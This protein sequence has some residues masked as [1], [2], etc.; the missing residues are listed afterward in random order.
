[1]ALHGTSQYNSGSTYVATNS[2]A[3]IRAAALRALDAGG[4]T[5]QLPAGVITITSPLPVG[6]GLVYR[7][8]AATG[9]NYTVFSDLGTILAGDGTFNCFEW[10]TDDVGSLPASSTVMFAD[11]PIGFGLHDFKMRGFRNGVKFG[12][13]RHVGL[14]GLV[15]DNVAAERCTEW[16]FWL[17]NCQGMKIGNI[18]SFSNLK[19]Q[20]RHRCSM[21][22]IWYF[23]N[24]V[25]QN[26][27]CAVEATGGNWTNT[28]LAN[29]RGIV[30][31]AVG[32][33]AIMNDLLYA[34]IQMNGYAMSTITQSATTVYSAGNPTR[35]SITGNIDR[36]QV[37]NAIQVGTT[38]SGFVAQR[39]YFITTVHD[40]GDGT[41]WIEVSLV[42]GGTPVSASDA[43]TSTTIIT[44][45]AALLEVGGVGDATSVGGTTP[46]VMNYRFLKT[47]L[48]NGGSVNTLL[49]S[50]QQGEMHFGLVSGANG[51]VSVCANGISA[52]NTL[53]APALLQNV[54]FYG[55]FSFYGIRP[56]SFLTGTPTSPYSFR[57]A[58]MDTVN[59]NRIRLHLGGTNPNGLGDL[60]AY[61]SVLLPNLPI[62]MQLQEIATGPTLDGYKN[63]VVFNGASD[64][65]LTLPAPS[66]AN[67][68]SWWLFSNPTAYTAKLFS[69]GYLI[70]GLTRSDGYALRPHS[71]AIATITSNGGVYGWSVM[72]IGDEL[73]ASK[74]YNPGS[75]SSG[76]PV[77]TTITVTGVALG[78]TVSVGASIDPGGLQVIGYVSAADTV[79][80]QYTCPSSSP[81]SMGSHTV[82][83][84]VRR[85]A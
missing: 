7:G 13:Y 84:Y 16:G 17:E 25:I 10:N 55:Q 82:T 30:V 36:Y 46:F 71:M 66:S 26:L 81:I 18:N 48:E 49:Q 57:G 73:S 62:A 22:A 72:T 28:Q 67:A 47:D 58:V 38:G 75:V 54:Y 1:M 6:S 78:D 5:V 20:W 64:Q 56:F 85:R 74:T 8:A 15:M 39:P 37:D 69:T 27:N 60:S 9:V 19:G 59:N 50:L 45:G 11:S 14:Q 29:S 33:G 4:G 34:R 63:A 80:V 24:D 53:Y 61:G 21:G 12:A 68:G 40:N 23:G 41:G 35:I 2:D 52:N 3:S 65:N 44:K 76:T 31:E 51:T 77:S 79:T 42:K 70:N 32:A 83:A 43:T